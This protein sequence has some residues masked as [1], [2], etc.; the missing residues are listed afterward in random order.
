MIAEIFREPGA[1]LAGVPV[2][3]LTFLVVVTGAGLAVLC[4][5]ATD[6]PALRRLAPLLLA[7]TGG[8]AAVW[9]RTHGGLAGPASQLAVTAAILALLAWHAALDPDAGATVTSRQ[10]VSGGGWSAGALVVAVLLATF[11]LGWRLRTF[12]GSTLVWEAP[13]TTGFGAAFYAHTGTLGY[14]ARTLLWNEGLVSNGDASFLYGAP[15]YALLTHAGFSTLSLRLFAALWALL[16]VPALWL[17]ARRHF[18]PTAAAVTALVASAN[19]YVIF[20]GKYGTSLSATVLACVV[21]ALA[22]GELAAPGGAAWWRGLVAGVALYVATLGYSP[23]RL[24]VIALLASLVPSAVRAWRD[25]RRSALAA[26]AVLAAVAI[27]VTSAQYAAGGQRTFLHARGEQLFTILAETDYVRDYLTQDSAAFDAFARWAKGAGLT[28]LV[29]TAAELATVPREGP[30]Q[31]SPAQRFEV[32]FKVLA[33]TLPQCYR[34]LSPF[35]MASPGSQSIFEDPPAIKAY[36]A[37]F[38]ALTLLGFVVSLRRARQWGHA[39]LLAWFAITVLPV[40]LTTR[41]D[42]HRTVLL[43]VPLCVWTAIGTGEAGRALARLGVR[44]APRVA[45]GASLGVLLLIGTGAVVLRRH[46][47]D[48]IQRRLLDAVGR[49]PGP[50]VVGALID[51]RQRTWIELGLLER[52]RR[53][54]AAEGRM[55]DPGLREE[56]ARPEGSWPPELLDRTS[57]VCA[58]AALVLAPAGSYRTAVNRLEGRGLRARELRLPELSAWLVPR[59]EIPPAA[60]AA[61]SSPR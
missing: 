2:A 30:F 14:A 55:L 16:L 12:A 38:A 13:V 36:F 53:D 31:P 50:V 8:T 6:R 61:P 23:G 28:R 11:A 4:G 34:L 24:V 32:A 40:L 10:P 52:T 20:Y 47:D 45:L 7:L 25:R 37:P 9:A 58:H 49:L 44:P 33:E 29:P 21:A 17:F 15:T 59:Q 19:T 51:V 56:L 57:E 43:A 42:A 18:G 5:L 39:V 48:G 3:A 27:G 35:S 22:V 26:F 46:T 41:C 60:G 1:V 54:R